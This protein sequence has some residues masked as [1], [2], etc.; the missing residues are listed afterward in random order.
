MAQS[1]DDED[2]KPLDPAVERV[3][4]RVLRFMAINM[5]VLFLALM[6]VAIAIV[7]RLGSDDGETPPGEAGTA[8]GEMAAE[9]VIEL[10]AGARI[11]SQTLSDGLLAVRIELAG[12][13]GQFLIYDLAAGAVVSRIA[14]TTTR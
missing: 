6:A 1:L 9:G 12:G 13:E 3:R 8:A 2:E 5:A 10:P 14:V 7:Y 11:V 4:R